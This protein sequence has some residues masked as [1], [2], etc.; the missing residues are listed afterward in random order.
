MGFT[1]Y[2]K[3]YIGESVSGLHSDLVLISWIGDNINPFAGCGRPYEEVLQTSCVATSQY[4]VKVV[5]FYCAL[6]L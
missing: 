3:G 2:S 6:R 1:I 4:L 5:S